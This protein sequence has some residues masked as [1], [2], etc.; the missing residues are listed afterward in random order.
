MALTEK[1]DMLGNIVA[2]K[3]G[4]NGGRFVAAIGYGI[5]SRRSSGSR[6]RRKEAKEP[7]ES[8]LRLCG[9]IQT[10]VSTTLVLKVPQR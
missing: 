5:E 3:R 8:E 7:S 1:R 10:K 4:L 2:V 6:G 9:T